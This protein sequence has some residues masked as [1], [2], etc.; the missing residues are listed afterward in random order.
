MEMYLSAHSKVIEDQLV[1][2]NMAKDGGTAE[3][4]GTASG[5][6][7]GRAKARVEIEIRK[8]MILMNG[9]LVVGCSAVCAS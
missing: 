8:R 5:R 7:G 3:N 1:D 6:G 9:Y 4:R 2:R